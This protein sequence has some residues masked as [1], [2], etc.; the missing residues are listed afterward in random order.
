MTEAVQTSPEAT[1]DAP[2]GGYTPEQAAALFDDDDAAI[3][4]APDLEDEGDDEAAEEAAEA[5]GESEEAEADDAEESDEPDEADLDAVYDIDGKEVALKDLVEAYKNK[6]DV[7][8]VKQEAAKE[9]V[10]KHVQQVGFYENT[11]A[12]AAAV[13]DKQMQAA[14]KSVAALMQLSPIGERPT[15]KQFTWR[16]EHGREHKNTEAYLSAV[17]DYDELAGAYAG[18]L[19]DFDQAAKAKAEIDANQREVE[20][21]KTRAQVMKEALQL[22]P[23]LSRDKLEKMQKLAK[24]HYGQ[25]DE[26]LENLG[27]AYAI[28]ALYDLMHYHE[29]RAKD[30]GALAKVKK[31]QP[32]VIKTQKAVE[33]TPT[34]APTKRAQQVVQSYKRDPSAAN[35]AKFF[36]TF[37]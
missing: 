30:S 12:N 28:K 8:A 21:D 14:A 20:R 35:L 33:R 26:S 18:I 3:D 15:L 34:R 9:A 17:A 24:E 4:A 11:L 13:F 2:V 22:I 36:D 23:D 10:E 6:P 31:A 1:H 7:E 29:I 25:T 5:E 16:D 19:N 32:K 27:S 37:S